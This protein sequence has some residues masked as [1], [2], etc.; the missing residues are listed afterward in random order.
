M[1]SNLPQL[2]LQR[3]L[4]RLCLWLRATTM[5]FRQAGSSASRLPGDLTT[6]T[7]LRARQH[8][9]SL[10]IRRI[11]INLF[12]VM[13]SDHFPLVGRCVL[14]L[15]AAFIL[16]TITPKRQPGTIHGCHLLWIRMS[17]NTSVTSA[18]NSSISAVNPQ[19]A[20]SLA[21]VRFESEGAISLKIRTPRSCA[22]HLRS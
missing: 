18:G 19:C 14:H 22:S 4:L 9:T 13:R 7:T 12:P 10:A 16:L 21:T 5:V 20:A 17:L 11:T 2:A 3:T 6:L 8:G 15:R 1:S